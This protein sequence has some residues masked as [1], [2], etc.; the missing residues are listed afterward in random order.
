MPATSP[1]FEV[2]YS[3]FSFPT[4]V[5][6][7]NDKLIFTADDLAHALFTTGRAPGD[8]NRYGK[9]SVWEFLHRTAIIPAY[10]RRRP[11]GS[12]VRS[13]LA[14]EL[15]RS[16]LV[17]LSYVLGM[18]LTTI[19]CRRQLSVP[20]LLHIDRYAAQHQIRFNTPR[21]RADLIGRAPNGWI[22]AEA[23]GRSRTAERELRT[24]LEQQKRSVASVGGERPWLAL[25]CVASFPASSEGVR[26]DA[27]DPSEND[28]ESVRYDEIALDGYFLAYYLPFINAIESGT[29]TVTGVPHSLI[30]TANFGPYGMTIGLIQPIADLTRRYLRREIADYSERIQAALNEDAQSQGNAFSDGTVIEANW[31]EEMRAPDHWTLH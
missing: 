13:G 25:G 4:G 20:H 23:K 7:P 6:V 16:E 24:K 11:Y 10:I 8:Q 18:A 3:A 21:K 9:A 12:L 26:L 27:F 5:V 2:D 17:G 22:V 30:E 1:S 29:R 19:F 31:S 15:D 14:Q 28:Q